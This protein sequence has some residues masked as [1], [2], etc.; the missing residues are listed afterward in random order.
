MIADVNTGQTP[1][2][3]VC[4]MLRR[5]L[6]IPKKYQVLY[7]QLVTACKIY[8]AKY[9]FGSSNYLRPSQGITI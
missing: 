5:K 3:F 8:L 1:L 9:F 6:I 2:H 7:F 4:I